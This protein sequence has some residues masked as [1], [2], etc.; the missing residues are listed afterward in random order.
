M[1]RMKRYFHVLLATVML[2][3]A[4]S[5]ND[6][7]I[8]QSITDTVTEV[9]TDSSFT[10][11][12]VTVK[13][14]VLPARTITKLLGIISA[15]NYGVLTTD[16]VTQ[17][18]PTAYIDTVGVSV[19]DIDSCKFVFDIPAGGFTGDSV[20]P[21]RTTIYKL[22]KALPSKLASNFDPSGYYNETDILGTTSYT[23][24]AIMAP[25][26]LKSEYK[27]NSLFEFTV[28]APVS[29]AKEIFTKFKSDKSVFMT[30]KDFVKFF[31]GVYI[32]NSFGSG[33]VMNIYNSQFIVFYHRHITK[34]D[35]TDSIAKASMGYMGG[36]AEVLS[37][38]NI[39]LEVDQA[40]NDM[41][42]D[43]EMIVQSPSGFEV[44]I[45]FPIQDII[46]KFLSGGDKN[47]A[48]INDL[49]FELP[50]YSLTNDYGIKPPTYLLM[51]KTSEK[52]E[53]FATN[54]NV[55]NKSS[56]YA[57]YDSS[58]RVYK[59]TGMRNFVLDIIKNK[60]GVAEESD[61]NFTLTPV[62][63]IAESTSTSS[64]SYYYYYYYS[65]ASSTEVIGIRPAINKPTIAKLDIK[66]AK[67][68][69]IYSTQ[70]IRNM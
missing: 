42:A 48:V 46:D 27:A 5:C 18:M 13:N 16:V 23:A 31:P 30:P 29:L 20:A 50:A 52:D 15:K 44:Q 10:V 22:N 28:D 70:S 7:N 55:D 56:F 4:I 26:S 12:G 25:D 14:T 1:N 68:K 59:F 37:N 58:K 38:N 57:I 61:I 35:G 43:G 41:I 63:L 2:S 69:L 9:V 47:L 51:V 40:V 17:F 49:S 66:N 62:D 33:R 45:R 24:S 21:M 39:R 6:N 54:H 53:F 34:D 19:D 32:K 65:T 60:N 64:S 11:T 8:G 67:I 3:A 36:S